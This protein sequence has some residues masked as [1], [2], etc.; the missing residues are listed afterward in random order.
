MFAQ[1][2]L[3]TFLSYLNMVSMDGNADIG[4]FGFNMGE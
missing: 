4:E 3:A 2:G 1:V